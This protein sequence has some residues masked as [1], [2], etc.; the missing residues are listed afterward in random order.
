MRSE[1]KK[2]RACKFKSHQHSGLIIFKPSNMVCFVDFST[3]EIG[4]NIMVA[5]SELL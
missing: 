3:G 4:I 5:Q 2:L 1:N